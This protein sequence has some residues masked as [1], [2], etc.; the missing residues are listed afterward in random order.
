MTKGLCREDT[1]QTAQELTGS[2]PSTGTCTVK[3]SGNPG[4]LTTKS[5]HLFREEEL[6]FPAM[7]QE[8]AT[9]SFAVPICT[10]WP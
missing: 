9:G 8:N 2:Q 7:C 10:Q 3:K 5:H 6:S 1:A 4:P